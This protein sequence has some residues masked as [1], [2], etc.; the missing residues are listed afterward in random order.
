M[1][2]GCLFKRTNDLGTVIIC[3]YV[4]DM[5]IIGDNEAIDDTHKQLREHYTLSVEEAKA[6]LGCKWIEEEDKL[7][8]YQPDIFR[9]IKK[10]FGQE[11]KEL[12]QYSLPSGHGFKVRRIEDYETKLDNTAQTRFRSGVGLALYLSR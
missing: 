11:L 9:K 10:D 4:D 6:F 2:D 3:A 12:K 1:N 7:L 5:L 8:L